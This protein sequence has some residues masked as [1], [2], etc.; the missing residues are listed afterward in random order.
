MNEKMNLTDIQVAGQNPYKVVDITTPQCDNYSQF[1]EWWNS[2]T[3]V[4][5]SSILRVDIEKLPKGLRYSAAELIKASG[6]A[7][8]GDSPSSHYDNRSVKLLILTETVFA[9]VENRS[10][11]VRE[12]L[13][14]YDL[15]LKSIADQIAVSGARHIHF[16]YV[17]SDKPLAIA[18]VARMINKYNAESKFSEF[19]LVLFDHPLEGYPEPENGH[20]DRKMRPSLFGER[21]NILFSKAFS[22]LAL[23]GLKGSDLF[24]R[25][26]I[27]DDD[28]WLPWAMKE[29]AYQGSAL[30]DTP[31][32]DNRCIGFPHQYIFYPIE[33]GRLD[34][35]SMRMVMPGAKFN[36]SRSWD[37]IESRHPWMLPESFSANNERRLRHQGVDI[38]LAYTARPS[39]IYI[40]R[41]G[42]LSAITK[43]EHY[44]DDPVSFS[45][46]GTE[47][48]SLEEAIRVDKLLF[49]R[50][51]PQFGFDP[52]TLEARGDFD[53]RSGKL[54]IQVNVDEV[55]HSRGVDTTGFKF[56]LTYG[57]EHG[58]S[59]EFVN[60]NST[61]EVDA[62]LWRDRSVLVV[63]DAD[64]VE[65]MGTWIRGNERFLS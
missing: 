51:P 62:T 14:Y 7:L 34:S 38:R 21:P 30:M 13:G 29:F 24:I 5:G 52:S 11:K 36:I 44:R 10:E 65:L 45:G 53:S 19:R 15:T 4:D 59:S 42:R 50:L 6:H 64:G 3:E 1:V 8:L 9:D 43:F 54:S 33:A 41:P 27:D 31:G 46:I 60:F 47:I 22:N 49:N 39:S 61:I 16:T 37:I 58:R 55:F 17:S 12:F 40:R 48:S 32:R 18:T 56:K 57:T 28:A 25:S 26:S 35:V 63:I 2:S 23:P 20:I